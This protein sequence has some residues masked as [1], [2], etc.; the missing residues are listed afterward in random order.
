M[1]PASYAS[2][3][4]RRSSSPALLLFALMRDY[5]KTVIV[6]D[7]C[8]ELWYSEYGD[9]SRRKIHRYLQTL[10]EQGLVHSVARSVYSLRG[11][12]YYRDEDE[13]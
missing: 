11:Y 2:E 4:L 10:R 12:K 5:G 8:I 3:I 9:I 13:A 1:I 7:E 6:L